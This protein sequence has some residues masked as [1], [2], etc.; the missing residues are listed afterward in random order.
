MTAILIIL[1]F[2]LFAGLMISR[3][4]PAI[5]AV[6]AMA[7]CVAAVAR[8]PLKEILELVVT[9]GSIKLANQYLMVIAGAM[10]GRVVMQ[11]G[12]AESMI[13]RAAEFGGDRPMAVA[14][15]MMVAVAWLF[16]TLTG[17]GAIIMVGGLALPIMM[18]IGVPRKLTGILFLLAFALGFVFNIGMWGFYQG[19]FNIDPQAIKQFAIVL[20]VIDAA[21]L[22]V[23]LAV[24]SRRM[25]YYGAWA[26]AT[27][28]EAPA[29]KH[30]V[31]LL[32][33]A[34]PIVPLILHAGLGV[35][36]VAAFLIGALLGVLATRP[37]EMVRQLSSA[38]VKGL[39]D[40][41]PAVI[42]MVGIGMLL[43]ATTLPVVKESLTPLIG[44]VNLRSPWVYVL[45]FGLL[46]PLALYRGPL[47]PYGIGIGIYLLIRDLNLLPPL[48]LLAAVMSVVQVQNTCDP[49]NTQNVWIANYVGMRV[50]EITRHTILFKVAVCILGLVAGAFLY[51][52]S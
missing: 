16:T 21:V 37:K 30:D 46:S 18:S 9:N 15:T 42:L 43:N 50:E 20:A 44:A 35:P 31:P 32:A 12:I 17:L 13:K 40:V 23:F 29:R 49:T 22:A 24:A 45:F 38:A 48:A 27:E 25:R 3:R 51:L 6:P 8:T 1:V 2:V 19:T 7:V 39:E 33:L 34:I 47:N 41:A 52:R 36:V 14:L 11:T 26:M 4:M 10:L 5:L 28:E